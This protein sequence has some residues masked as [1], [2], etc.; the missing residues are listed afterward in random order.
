MKAIGI[1]ALALLTPALSG[2]GGPAAASAPESIHIDFAF[3]ENQWVAFRV[4]LTPGHDFRFSNKVIYCTG[5]EDGNRPVRGS[6]TWLVKDGLPGITAFSPG[7]LDWGAIG[8]EELIQ[9]SQVAEA[10]VA[11]LH[12]RAPSH[13]DESCSTLGGDEPTTNPIGVSESYSKVILIMAPHG[14]FW[15]NATW[16][17]GVRSWDIVV[18]DGVAKNL[19]MFGEGAHADVYPLGPGAGALLHESFAPTG[20]LFGFFAPDYYRSA[21]TMWECTRDGMPCPPGKFP[22]MMDLI[23]HG[24]TSW[25]MRVDLDVSAG[26]IPQFILGAVELPDDSYFY[27]T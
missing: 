26:G 22:R 13:R 1:V 23:S 17:T 16:T 5:A 24:P 20:D 19:N 27:A 9:Y 4:N 8:Q 21:I 3:E 2:L 18:G 12:V 14:R 7:F 25:D 6:V 15:L 10:G 11:G